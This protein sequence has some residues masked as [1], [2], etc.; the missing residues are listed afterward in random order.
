MRTAEAG[1]SAR[2]IMALTGHKTL[3]GVPRY[4]ETAMREGLADSAQAKLLSRPDREQTV[5][6]LPER[7]AINPPSH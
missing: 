7:F 4:K 3:A 1:A 5:M 6:N 2:E